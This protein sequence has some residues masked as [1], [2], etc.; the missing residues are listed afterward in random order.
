MT[1]GCS[2]TNHSVRSLLDKSDVQRLR[3]SHFQS[4]NLRPRLLV[5]KEYLSW[6]EPARRTCL[7][8][9]RFD[10]RERR[11]MNVLRMSLASFRAN[12]CREPDFFHFCMNHMPEWRDEKGLT[13]K[14]DISG[15]MFWKR[16]SWL[17]RGHSI[18]CIKPLNYHELPS[19]T[20]KFTP[21]L[22]YVVNARQIEQVVVTMYYIAYSL[23]TT[24]RILLIIPH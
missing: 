23:L 1:E 2:E 13:I 8:L 19:K 9:W 16:F 15:L 5:S 20:G 10:L 11:Y 4:R 3:E 7:N 17:C 18:V 24:S 6:V 21:S 14:D 12:W 22:C